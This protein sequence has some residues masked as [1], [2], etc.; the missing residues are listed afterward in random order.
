ERDDRGE[1]PDEDRAVRVPRGQLDRRQEER[2]R[3][4]AD[5]RRS[6]R[7]STGDPACRDPREDQQQARGEDRRADHSTVVSSVGVA[8]GGW[9][10]GG[11]A[12]IGATAAVE[13][14]GTIGAAPSR[15]SEPTISRPPRPTMNTGQR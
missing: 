3:G 14:D 12:A 10:A 5:P 11:A 4:T 2:P 15:R 6:D 8:D 13:V 1:E 9:L 7:R